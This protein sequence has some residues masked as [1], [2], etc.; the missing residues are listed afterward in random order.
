MKS[1]VR[2]LIF[3]RP[4]ILFGEFVHGKVVSFLSDNNG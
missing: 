1:A 4:N 2:V 3:F